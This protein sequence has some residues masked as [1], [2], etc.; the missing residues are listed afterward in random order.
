MTEDIQKSFEVLRKGGVILYPTDSIWGLGCDA[1]NALAAERIFRIKD[2]EDAKSMLILLDDPGR[3]ER[4]VTVPE[5]AWELIESSDSPITI[6]YPGAKNLAK[7]LIADD[8]SAGI[9]ITNDPFC[10]ALI[11]KLGKPIVSTSA[12][13][14]GQPSPSVFDEIDGDIISQVDYT[15]QWRQDDIYSK[16]PSSIIKIEENG[17]FKIIRK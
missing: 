2:R 16:K 5:I 10:I 7:G 14:S 6:I 9:R 12:N 17:V 4:Y 13:K 15:V 1:T 8:G 11:R 3:L